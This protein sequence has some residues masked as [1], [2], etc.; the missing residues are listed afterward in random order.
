M[1][2]FLFNGLGTVRIPLPSLG[3]DAY[4][5]V[6]DIEDQ[7]IGQDA[8]TILLDFGTW[9]YVK[10]GIIMK[11]RA[12]SI[13]DRGYSETGDFSGI[14][15]RLQQHKYTKILVRDLDSP[16]FTYDYYLWPRSS[17]IKQVLLSNYHVIGKING[18]DGINNYLLGEISILVPVDN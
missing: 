4:R 7:F 18:V 17:G 10:D 8:S 15:Q 1:I 12:P 5:Y 3:E 13:G 11:D 9:V 2:C 16:N 14:I 6:S